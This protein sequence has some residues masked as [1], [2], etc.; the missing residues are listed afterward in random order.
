MK[1]ESTDPVG[2]I[3]RAHRADAVASKIVYGLRGLAMCLFFLASS[4]G[5]S[6][7]V[8]EANYNEAKVPAYTLPDPLVTV[9]GHKVTDAS[10][11]RET[12]RPEIVRLFETQVYGKSPGRPKDERFAVTS[13]DRNALGGKAIRK[14]VTVYFSPEAQP[15]MNV[16]L[17]L[18]AGAKAPT[19]VFLGLNFSGNHAVSVDPGITLA[20]SWIGDGP[21]VVNSRATEA[22][23]GSGAGRWAIEKIL[24]RGYGVAT[25]YCGD[26]DPDFDD[27]FGNGV[28]PLFYAPGQSAPEPDQW[29]AIG[30]WAWGLSRALDYFETDSDVDA[31]KV[32]VLGHSRLG[33]AAVWAGA[34]DERFAVVISNESGCG[35]AAL[36][37]RMFGETVERI[38]TRFPHWFCGN[39]R[40]YNDNEAALPLDQHMLLALVAPRPLY[41][42][43][44][45]EDRW[46]DPK[47]EFLSLVN[48]DPVYRLL[49]KPGL[50][51]TEMP[52]V[53]TPVVS[54]NGYHIRT[55]RH[56]VTD[57]DWERYL[58]FADKYFKT[59]AQ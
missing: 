18:P 24:A 5:V 21:G 19:P 41:V 44:A 51:V 4:A 22:S 3:R 36:S 17:Y 25:I 53:N 54:F 29:G 33:K 59:A 6:G 42:A 26:L 8:R 48:A 47:G 56:D 50:G 43:S 10:V 52:P 46:A 55:G 38:N 49:G 11:W 37:R 40:K 12:R 28:H 13:I 15:Q 45:E 16:L 30:A 39:F 31:K 34:Q 23:R 32:A 35:G 7:Q 20:K 2:R 14:E 1:T 9:D 57:Y 27:G 58:D